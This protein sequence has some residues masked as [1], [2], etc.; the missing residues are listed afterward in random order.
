MGGGW[1]EPRRRAD[2]CRS[3][4]ACMCALE[5]VGGAGSQG[6]PRVACVSADGCTPARAARRAC[7]TVRLYV[8]V[9]IPHSR[10]RWCARACMRLK[11]ERGAGMENT[12]LM[13]P[14]ALV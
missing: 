10:A 3:R 5:R 4:R 8:S 9:R 11:A 1:S 7:E 12:S 6:G 2:T 14:S 13:S